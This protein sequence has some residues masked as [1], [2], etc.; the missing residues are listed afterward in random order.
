MMSFARAAR[1]FGAAVVFSVAYSAASAQTDTIPGVSTP[2]IATKHRITLNG[3]LLAYTARAGMLPIR[4]NETGE[5]RG[6]IF[7]VSYTVDRAPG[8]PP[9]PLTFA[10]NGGPGANALLVHLSALGPRR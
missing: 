6:Y 9:R 10:W 3:K 1:A 5:P 4:L 7:F 2:I 8:Q